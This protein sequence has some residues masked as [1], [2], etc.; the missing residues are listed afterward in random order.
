MRADP[1]GQVGK[2][3]HT[4]CETA[5]SRRAREALLDRS[6]D[7]RSAVRDHEQRIAEATAAHVLEEGPNRLGVLLPAMRCSRTLPPS[8]PMPQAA[9]TGSRAWPARSRSAMPS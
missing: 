7:A 1:S 2:V 6:D 8:S 4:V 3:A 9:R 5:L